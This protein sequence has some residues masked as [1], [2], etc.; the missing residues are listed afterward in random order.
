VRAKGAVPAVS[1]TPLSL[2]PRNSN[3][4]YLLCTSSSCRKAGN[5]HNSA[6]T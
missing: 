3:P 1:G 5:L 6:R 2:K 4:A